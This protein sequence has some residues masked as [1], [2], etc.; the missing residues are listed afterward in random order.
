MLAYFVRAKRLLQS[1]ANLHL[2]AIDG[3]TVNVTVAS[4]QGPDYCLFNLEYSQHNHCL[5][6]PKQQANINT[7]LQMS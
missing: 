7:T 3:S 6:K 1:L 4:L 2:V 5:Q